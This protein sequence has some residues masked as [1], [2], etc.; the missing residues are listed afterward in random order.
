MPEQEA[1][2]V[3]AKRSVSAIKEQGGCVFQTHKAIDLLLS[4]VEWSDD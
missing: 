4:I 1:E 3:P 2:F